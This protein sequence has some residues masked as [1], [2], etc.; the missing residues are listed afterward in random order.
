[1]AALRKVAGVGRGRRATLASVESTAKPV[2]GRPP[3]ELARALSLQQLQINRLLNITQAINSNVAPR[4]LFRMYADFLAWELGIDLMALYLLRE[5]EWTEAARIG[6][7]PAA[8]GARLPGEALARFTAMT[9]IDP[10][11]PAHAEFAAYDLVIPVA[12]KDA[13]IA[14]VLLGGV[15]DTPEHYNKVQLVST[16]TNIIAVA[17]ENR[18]LFETQLEQERYRAEIAL[19]SEVQRSLIPARLPANEHFDLAAIYLPRFG[20]GGDFYSAEAL[21][22]GRLL[23]CLADIAG[24]GPGAA[25]LMSNFEASFWTLAQVRRDLADFVHDLNAALFRVTRGDRFVTLVVGEYDPRER[26]LTYVNAGHN[27]PLFASSDSGHVEELRAGCTFLG[28]FERLPRVDVGRRPVGDDDGIL[29][30][31][32]DGVTELANPAGEMYGEERLARFAARRLGGGEAAGK[33]SADAFN[34]ELLDELG[35]FRAGAN[36][37]DDLSVLT[38]AIR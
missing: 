10:R 6:E 29:L 22:D 8:D 23:F 36:P 34:A 16:I 32:T 25:L 33:W 24:K 17:V 30:C 37:T 9:E 35:A 14:Y 13:P 20:V 21:P 28:A 2:P 11:R 19:A 38:L 18:R 15:E 4:E 5:G 7:P 26:L 12:H 3:A 31:Y 27:P 1:M